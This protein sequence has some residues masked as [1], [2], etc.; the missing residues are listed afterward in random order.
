MLDSEKSDKIRETAKMHLWPNEKKWLVAKHNFNNF[1]PQHLFT[2][3]EKS[4]IDRYLVTSGM[5]KSPSVK[6]AL[7]SVTVGRIRN[8][9]YIDF[10]NK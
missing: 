2:I 9:M 3:Y 1:P 7:D 8:I 5:L 6:T 10:Q 4:F